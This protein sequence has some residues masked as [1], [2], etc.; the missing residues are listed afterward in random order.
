MFQ[1]FSFF[2]EQVYSLDSPYTIDYLIVAGGGG[3]SRNGGGGGG[4]GCGDAGDL[5]QRAAGRPW[6]AARVVQ[7]R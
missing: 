5:P 6:H 2:R 7:H 1:P 3:S 4:A